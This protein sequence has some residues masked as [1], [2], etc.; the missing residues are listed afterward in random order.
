MPRRTLHIGAVTDEIA[1]SLSEALEAG[2]SWGLT[3]FELREGSRGRF[4]AFTQDEVAAVEAALRGGV[5]VTAVSPGIFKGAA[6]DDAR[7]RH[8][9]EE[10]L[11]RTIEMAVRFGCPLVIVFGFERYRGEPDGNRTRAMRAWAQAAEQA[12]K[13]GLRVAIENEPNFWIDGPQTST[14]L[15]GEIGHPAL[16][17]N[18]DPANLHWGGHVPTSEDVVAVEPYLEGLHVKDYAPDRPEAP[19]VPVG[20]GAT[21]WEDLFGWIARETDLPHVTLETHCEPLLESSKKSLETMRRLIAT[22]TSEIE[23]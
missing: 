20:E 9:L 10:V 12:S 1:R 7:L 15:L 3:R 4:P 11:P 13:A 19:W 6:D 18:W 17:L 22:A 16:G 2:T 21:P 14:A 23:P 8:E 5:R